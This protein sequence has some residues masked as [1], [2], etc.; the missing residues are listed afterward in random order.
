M[1]PPFDP[2]TIPVRSR[3]DTLPAVDPA[4]LRADWLR[5]RFA[6]PPAWSP[7]AFR[8]I[9]LE[10]SGGTRAASVLVGLVERS[11]GLHLLLTRRNAHL[12]VHGGQISFPGGSRDSGDVDAVH[13]ALREAHEEIGLDPA[14]VEPLGT[15][16]IY[17]T[18]TGFAVTPVIAM[19]DRAALMRADPQEVAELFEVPLVF[20]MNPA[21]HEHRSWNPLDGTA[22]GPAT[23]RR[24]FYAMPWTSSQGQRYFIWGATAAM[25]RNL[26]RLLIA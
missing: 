22:A 13:T 12:Q 17:T 4:R 7:E 6:R 14:R 21:N 5:A 26:Y 9:G 15:M 10:P 23:P 24:S 3:D 2:E 11:Q 20:L 18:I 8:D 25:I 16:P 1:L 19:V